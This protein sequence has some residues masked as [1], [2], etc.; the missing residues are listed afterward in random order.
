MNTARRE[1]ARLDIERDPLERCSG[2]DLATVREQEF[3]QVSLANHRYGAEQSSSTPGVC[4]NC[5]AL[6]LPLAVYCDEDCRAD[7]ERRE[8]LLRRQGRRSG[9]Q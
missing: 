5:G 7:H 3:L 1:L 2:D 4:R 9:G 8:L 6:C